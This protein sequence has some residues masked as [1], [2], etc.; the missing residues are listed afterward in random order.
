MSHH[1]ADASFLLLLT[2]HRVLCLEQHGTALAREGN[3]LE[4]H[5]S[6]SCCLPISQFKEKE[7]K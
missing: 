3:I 2:H 4:R 5:L 7:R 1:D 6:L